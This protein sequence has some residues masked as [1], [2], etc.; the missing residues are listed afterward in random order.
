M[1]DNEIPIPF[2]VVA[3]DSNIFLSSKSNRGNYFSILDRKTE[4]W[5]VGSDVIK[6]QN[7]YMS[8]PVLYHENYFLREMADYRVEHF[9]KLAEGVD[10]SDPK[11]KEELA[12]LDAAYDERGGKT[13]FLLKL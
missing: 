5:I 10:P 7:T 4:K 3:D 6:Y 8:A 2:S 11:W 1:I 12:R 13:I 9:A